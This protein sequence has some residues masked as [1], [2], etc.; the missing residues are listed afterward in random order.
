MQAH[1]ANHCEYMHLTF[2]AIIFMYSGT[3]D[4]GPSK[5][6]TTSHKGHSSKYHYLKTIHFESPRKDKQHSQNSEGSS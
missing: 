4:K 3:S 1:G 6:G 5:K 2:L